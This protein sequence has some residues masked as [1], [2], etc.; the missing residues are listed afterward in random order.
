MQAQKNSTS[1]IAFFGILCLLV[2][3]S[4]FAT[5]LFSAC[6]PPPSQELTDANEATSPDQNTSNACVGSPNFCSLRYDQ[7]LFPMA[8]NA[9]STAE[10]KWEL[11]LQNWSLSKQMQ[12]GVRG[13]MLDTY[14]KDGQ[15]WLC[16]GYCEL[17]KKLLKDGLSEIKDFLEKNPREI[18]TIEFE[19]HA[20]ADKTVQIFRDIGLDAL[21]HT[22]SK[23]AT[24]PTLLA[25]I[26]SNKRLVVLADNEGG[27]I[28]D[29]PWY[30]KTWQ[31]AWDNPYAAKKVEDFDCTRG[32]GDQANRIFI[33][34]HFITAPLG[35]PEHAMK[36]NT[37]DALT[38]HVEQCQKEL[39]RLPNFIAVDFVDIG[40]LFEVIASFH[41]QLTP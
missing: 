8:H 28:Q 34:N 18:I 37:R 38:Q 3:L 26:Q 27:T 12:Q 35:L 11:P 40:D 25:M 2:L 7:M 6:Q 36:A 20:P 17:G 13:L 39:Q 15:L 9:M 22:Q 24:W 29:A 30:H 19:D 10:E 23:D 14:E 4:S 41:P 33:M 16:H 31:L 21:T 5:P 1:N 32:R